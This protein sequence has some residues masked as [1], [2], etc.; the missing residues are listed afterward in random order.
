MSIYRKM[1]VTNLKTQQLIGYLGRGTKLYCEVVGRERAENITWA[2]KESD[3]KTVGLSPGI[4]RPESAEEWA[5]LGW[6]Y[7]AIEKPKRLWDVAGE[8]LWLLDYGWCNWSWSSSYTLVQ[9]NENHT[10][11]AM[12]EGKNMLYVD[13]C[14]D[15]GGLWLRF[16]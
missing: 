1:K 4:K 3:V 6:A 7:L 12:P 14:P 15:H 10:V 16:G 13:Q 2:M 9:W 5:S 11:S 8:Q